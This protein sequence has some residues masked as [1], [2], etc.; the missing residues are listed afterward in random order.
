MR[1]GGAGSGTKRADGV[2][3]SETGLGEGS[4]FG[5]PSLTRTKLFEDFQTENEKKAPGNSFISNLVQRARSG[6]A[7]YFETKTP[8][9]RA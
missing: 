7:E 9:K 5:R 4:L 2:R 1:P 6:C 8:L 3:I